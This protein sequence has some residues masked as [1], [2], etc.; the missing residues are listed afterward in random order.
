MNLL[1]ADKLGFAYGELELFRDLSFGLQ[2]G[3]KVALVGRNGCGKSSLLRI[4]AQVEQP[5]KGTF[6][7][8]QQTRVGFLDQNPDFG[9]AKTIDEAVFNPHSEVMK[10]LSAY[11]HL[12]LQPEDTPSYHAEFQRLIGL[13]TELNAWDLE[14]KAR[15]LLT[16]LGIGHLE[17][18]LNSLSGGQKKRVAL[19]RL[20]LDDPDFLILDEP[21]NHLDIDAVEYLEVLLSKPDKTVLFTT[22]DRYFLDQVANRILEIDHKQLFSYKGKYQYYLEKKAAQEQVLSAEAEKARNLLRREME[23]LRRQPKARGTKSKARVDAVGDLQEKASYKT[24]SR[25][26]ELSFKAHYLGGKIL[27]L[28]N[29]KMSFG[30]TPIMN[31]FS[32]I[33][34]RK[35]R[36]GIVGRNGAG[37]TT[38]LNL[39]TGLLSP[40]DGNIVRG[41][42]LQMGYFNQEGLVAKDNQRVIEVVKEIAEV[43]EMEDGSKITAAQFLQRFLFEPARQHDFVH[44]LSG[45]E[46]RRLQLLTVLAKKPNF[47]I[48][49]EPT[50]DLDLSTLNLLEAFLE[51]FPGIMLVVSHDRYFLDRLTD[52]LFIFSGEGHVRDFN[53]NYADYRE[54]R[55]NQELEKQKEARLLKQEAQL[56]KAKVSTA[57]TTTKKKRSFKEQQE[58]ELLEKE[59]AALEVEQ[60]EIENKIGLGVS[61]H[62]QLAFLSN[63]L[64]E[65]RE[66]LEDKG[67]RWLE[68]A[69]IEG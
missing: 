44:N 13:L 65:L 57:T 7:F 1:S 2:Q 43:F 5:N 9:K 33:F 20:M 59:I 31:G 52:H 69:E 53:G 64:L 56:N 46:K 60:K 38:L 48:L 30:E 21:T 51:G 25:Q 49:D 50:N 34:K 47:L 15:K 54:W 11:E 23:W 28:H 32:Y 29:V 61:D 63:R 45:G 67:L 14:H 17:T 58:F 10:A 35:D 68:L 40:E 22:H 8:N 4:L 62:E 24:D 39:I 6:S 42:S 26:V 66:L 55:E 27:E 18:P 12:M 37:K 3:E 41:E 16:L 36:I 19:A